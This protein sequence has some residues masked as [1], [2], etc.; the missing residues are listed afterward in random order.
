MFEAVLFFHL[1]GATMWT[2]GHLI[3]TLSILPE[4]LRRR[5]PEPVRRFERVYE[6][7]GVPALAVQIATGLW[8]DPQDWLQLDDPAARTILL[9]LACVVATAALGLHARLKLI[10][11][12]T[13][14]SLPWL[15][16]HIVAVTLLALLFV[17]LGLS[18]RFGG[19]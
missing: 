9:K 11:N 6:R 13:P 1:L 8:L 4:A 16:C 19:A 3:L 17:G 7:V 18:F 15:G 12:L 10:P 5:D 14:R 2:G